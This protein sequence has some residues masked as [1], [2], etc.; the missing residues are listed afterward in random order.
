MLIEH[1]QT[2]SKAAP[3]MAIGDGLR[4]DGLNHWHDTDSD[5]STNKKKTPNCVLCYR[6]PK[7][8]SSKTSYKCSKCGVALHIKCFKDIIFLTILNKFKSLLFALS[9]LFYISNYINNL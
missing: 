7:K 1:G 2:K 6:P 4:T 5:V 8:L 9:L 3:V